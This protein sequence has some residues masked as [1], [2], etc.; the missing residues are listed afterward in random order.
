MFFL[1]VHLIQCLGKS[2]SCYKY[3]SQRMKWTEN[4]FH[5]KRSLISL[6]WCC[7]MKMRRKEKKNPILLLSTEIN[8]NKRLVMALLNSKSIKKKCF[9][10]FIVQII[11]RNVQTNWHRH[12]S[13]LFVYIQC[14]YLFDLS[15]PTNNR[16]TLGLVVLSADKSMVVLCNK[17]KILKETFWTQK[18]YIYTDNLIKLRVQSQ[19]CDASG[20]HTHQ[21][22]I[23][24]QTN[25]S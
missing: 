11:K 6:I 24:G 3:F 16:L 5:L 22:Y 21:P 25:Y 18:Q 4:L 14:I 1:S 2:L 23:L 9:V 20:I 19:I 12:R 10:R 13:Y 8:S 7:D 15:V 17:H